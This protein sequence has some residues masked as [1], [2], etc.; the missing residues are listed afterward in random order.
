MIIRQVSG[1]VC[2]QLMLV[3]LHKFSRGLQRIYRKGAEKF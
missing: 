2:T 1:N 3:E